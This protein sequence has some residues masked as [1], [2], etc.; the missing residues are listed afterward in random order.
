MKYVIVLEPG[1]AENPD[2]GVIIPDLPGCFSQGRTM[3]EAI[4][5]AQEA[6]SLW[7]ETASDE[8]MKLPSASSFSALRNAHPEWSGWLWATADVDISK[9]GDKTERVNVTLPLR[10]LRRLDALAKKAGDSRSGYIA[11]MVMQ[12]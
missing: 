12:A 11:R 5:N 4:S 6:A 1:S 2:F 3:D 8:G 9:L 7:L 10:T